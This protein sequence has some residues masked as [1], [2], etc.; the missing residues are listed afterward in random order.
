M[1]RAWPGL[2]FLLVTEWRMYVGAARLLARRPDV[3]ADAMPVRYAGA[4][5]ALL[6][7]FTVVSAVEL[8]ALH[9]ILPWHAARLV[10]DVVG[11]WGVVWCLGMTGCHYVYPHLVTPSALR[12]RTARK[13]DAV[14]VPWANVAAVRVRERS[15]ESGRALQVGDGLA[16]VVVG[17]RTNVELTLDTPLTVTDRG[18][19]HE[20][21]EVRVYADDARALVTTV[22]SRL[23]S[24]AHEPS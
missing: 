16:Q 15:T 18:V 12:L 22:R 2:R 24:G 9:L 3:P 11:I 4:V 20:V 21:R 8:V 19:T 10:A 23:D 6:W 13:A 7:A 5:A 1:R 14:T 17:Q